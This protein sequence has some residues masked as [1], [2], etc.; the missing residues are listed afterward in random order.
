MKSL[1]GY[2]NYTKFIDKYS[3]VSWTYLLKDCIEILSLLLTNFVKNNAP[4]IS[5]SNLL[6]GQC[7]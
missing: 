6:F 3:C 2:H 5:L 4:N 7:P 1:L